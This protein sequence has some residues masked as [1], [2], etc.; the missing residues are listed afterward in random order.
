MPD[1]GKRP[2][3]GATPS[4]SPAAPPRPGIVRRDPLLEPFADVIE[5][6]MEHIRSVETRLL[7][8][9]LTLGDFASGHEYFGLHPR[10]D[11][12]VFREWAPNAEAIYLIGDHSG[13]NPDPA[14]ALR[15]IDGNGVWELEIPPDV[16]GHESLYRLRMEWPGGGGDRIPAWARRVAQ[17]P[18]TLIF[19]AQVWRPETP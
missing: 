2:V 3:K 16:L 13:W 15:R 17:D 14:F 19:N 11:G 7:P 8:D 5:A 1:P 10:E 6:R 4:A 18:E 12:W 9:G